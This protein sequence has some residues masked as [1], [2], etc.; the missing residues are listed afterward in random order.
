ML[1]TVLEHIEFEHVRGI[2]V[3]WKYKPYTSS[4]VWRIGSTIIDTG[5]AFHRR[6]VLDFCRS[7]PTQNVLLTHHHEDHSGNAYHIQQQLGLGIYMHPEGIALAEYGFAMTFDRILIHGKPHRFTPLPLPTIIETETAVL[8][9]LH[10]PGHA[11]DHVCFLDKDRGQLFTGDMYVSSITQYLYAVEDAAEML[12]SLDFLLQQDFSTIICSHSAIIRNGRNKLQ[13]KA[14]YLHELQEKA[15]T[16]Y[17]QGQTIT[18]ITNQLLGK[19]TIVAY[20]TGYRFSKRNLIK[21]LI[22]GGLPQN[23]MTKQHTT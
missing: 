22:F 9:A 5:D 18:A 6:A 4:I 14:L 16:L 23:G 15:D 3:G 11:I 2:R 7:Q 8:H 13:R 10:T 19:E 17:R 1:S 12:K 21:S 20:A